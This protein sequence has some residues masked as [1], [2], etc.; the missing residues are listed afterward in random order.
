MPAVPAN[1]C[2]LVSMPYPTSRQ[3]RFPLDQ[4]AANGRAFLEEAILGGKPWGRHLGEDA[5]VDAGTPVLAIGDGEVIYAA[6]HASWWRRRGNWGHVVILGHTH[7]QDGQPFYSVYGHLGEYRVT[8]GI[9]VRGGETLGTVGNGRTRA[10]GWWPEPHL[11]FAMY[12]GPWEGKILPGYLRE[13]DERTKREYW[14]NPS[15]FVRGYPNQGKV[16]S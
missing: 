5:L 2:V 10:N 14:V 4:Y 1:S 6:L 3:L 15:E 9:S 11:H 13:N 8:P 16:A 12:R 7:A